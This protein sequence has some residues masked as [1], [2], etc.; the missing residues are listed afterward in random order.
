[1]IN[2]VVS[3]FTRPAYKFIDRTN[4]TV[5]SAVRDAW[6]NRFRLDIPSSE[7]VYDVRKRFMKGEYMVTDAEDEMPVFSAYKAKGK[8]R[9]FWISYKGRDFE[10]RRPGFSMKRF[11]LYLAGRKEPVG[12]IRSEGAFNRNWVINGL[13]AHFFAFATSCITGIRW[14]HKLCETS[15]LNNRT[16]TLNPK[17]AH[18]TGFLFNRGKWFINAI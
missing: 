14:L 8:G 5:A 15:R 3:G 18:Q 1:L 9:K 12:Y 7:S 16:L 10:L 6:Y 17:P 2:V 11:D 13:N 4:D